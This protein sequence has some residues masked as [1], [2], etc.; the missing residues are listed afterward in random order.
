M[1]S[2]KD[3]TYSSVIY[4]GKTY[5]FTLNRLILEEH[6]HMNISMGGMGKATATVPMPCRLT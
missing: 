3:A 1:S 4:R 6:P 2:S 5:T